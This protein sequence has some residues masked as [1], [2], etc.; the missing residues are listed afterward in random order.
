MP[1][2]TPSV[3]HTLHH[4]VMPANNKENDLAQ[5]NAQMSRQTLGFTKPAPVSA[6]AIFTPPPAS[7]TLH[8]PIQKPQE[9][10]TTLSEVAGLRRWYD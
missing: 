6:T 7:F 5:L 1:H 4:S 9:K 2:S 10:R 8:S 3:F